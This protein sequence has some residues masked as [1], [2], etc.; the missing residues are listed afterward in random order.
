MYF[1]KLHFGS[2]TSDWRLWLNDR[3]SELCFAQAD[4]VFVRSSRCE[5]SSLARLINGRPHKLPRWIHLHGNAERVNDTVIECDW[6]NE[7][8]IALPEKRDSLWLYSFCDFT[9][10][11]FFLSLKSNR[12]AD[13]KLDAPDW[14]GRLRITAKGK[15]AFIKLE[16][17]VSGWSFFCQQL[18]LRLRVRFP[19]LPPSCVPLARPPSWVSRQGLHP[20]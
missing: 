12:A 15:V 16:D 9:A 1:A 14:S 8:C 6:M 4:S 19:G 2:R 5:C 11:L 7:R 3:D 20:S 10:G 18:K 17:R 13:W